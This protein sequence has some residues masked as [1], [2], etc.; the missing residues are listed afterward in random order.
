MVAMNDGRT[1]IL[2]GTSGGGTVADI[3]VIDMSAATPGWQTV[4]GGNKPFSGLYPGFHWLPSG[5]LFF[6]RT[7]WNSHT[8]ATNEVS[9][10]TFSGPTNG[11]WTNLAAMNF[12]N[13]KE[14]ASVLLIDD[15]GATP[16]AKVFV[17][18][19]QAPGL[20][21][22]KESEIIDISTPAT[23][24]GWVQT[25]DMANVR[26][27]VACIILPTGK[28]MVVGGRQTS[29]RFDAAP[30][31]VF[32][33]EIYDPATDS[34]ATT[35]PMSYGRQYHSSV[36]LLPDAR[37]FASGGVDSSLGFGPAGNTQTAEAYS[38]E[39]L[40]LGARPTITTAP[41]TAGYG[42]TVAVDTPV[43]PNITSVCL[44]AP[45][46]PTHHTDTHQRYIKVGFSQTTAT[47]I[48]IEIPSSNNVAPPG[49]Y[50]L[51]IVDNAGVP[52]IGHFIQVI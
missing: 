4:V 25:S 14:G 26:I 39:Y 21:A 46:A 34:W 11:S 45:G 48:S 5:D 2:S 38:P 7:G 10:F 37:V 28:V 49:Y 36:V 12:P 20:P 8:L 33:G 40:T 41:I 32:V 27:G 35:P 43:A 47:Q 15:T 42:A 44:I 23:T 29:N 19:G 16:I 51:F 24:A 1:A 3:E 31:F 30:I 18:G 9:R 13:R 52:S 50:M 6:T 17:A 22:I